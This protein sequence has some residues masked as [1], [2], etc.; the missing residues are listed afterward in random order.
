MN[1][2]FMYKNTMGNTKFITRALELAKESEHNFKH[3]AV[4]VKSGKVVSEGMN[5]YS[6]IPV[7]GVGSIH[8]EHSALQAYSK[9]KAFIR[10]S[11]IYIARQAS[12]GPAMSKPCPRCLILLK[13]VGIKRVIYTTDKCGVIGSMY[14]K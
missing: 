8:A 3:G 1:M 4:L 13:N 6:K 9:H 7:P 2:N 5:K 10:D 12:Y 11:T 14:L